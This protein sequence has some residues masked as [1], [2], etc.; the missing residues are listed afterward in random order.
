MTHRNSRT[1]DVR[2]GKKKPLGRTT[3]ANYPLHDPEK[4]ISMTEKEANRVAG[5]KQQSTNKVTTHTTVEKAIK[6]A[7]K[8][9][10]NDGSAREIFTTKSLKQHYPD[11]GKKKR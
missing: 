5:I 6:A 10:R 1:G 3:V 2:V 11:A 7:V 9:S 4:R 8:R